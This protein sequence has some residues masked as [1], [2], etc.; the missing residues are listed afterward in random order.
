MIETN[1]SSNAASVSIYLLRSFI[2]SNVGDSL[3]YIFG[4]LKIMLLCIELS[5]FH[6]IIRPCV[7]QSVCT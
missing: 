2:V 6:P 3:V 4:G 5:T 1:P 7:C